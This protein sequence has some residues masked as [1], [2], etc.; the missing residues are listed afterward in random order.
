MAMPRPPRT[1][2]FPKRSRRGINA[3][4]V[5]LAVGATTLLTVPAARGAANY[6]P[7]PSSSGSHLA[8][9]LDPGTTAKIPEAHMKSTMAGITAMAGA[10]LEG[11]GPCP[12]GQIT[13]SLTPGSEKLAK[14]VRSAYGRAV[15][16]SIGLTVWNGQ[17]GRSPHCG[18]LPPW[19]QAPRGLTFSL[20]LRSHRVHAGGSLT[21]RLIARDHRS[22]PFE[23]DTGSVVEGVVVRPGTHD[24]V[25]VYSG[26]IA[27]TGFTLRAASGGSTPSGTAPTVIIGT[28]RCDGET[29]SA[30]SPGK[31]QA[32]VLVMDETGKT[33]R[34]LTP[35]VDLVVT[36]SEDG[37]VPGSHI[38]N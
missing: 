19:S 17:A 26:A 2:P 25:G 5:L 33:P 1:G 31:Y 7:I 10:H 15:L 8:S 14:K 29:G 30:L 27:G 28:A 11:I 36:S 9:C 35:A 18:S 13:L 16:I 6:P 32:V 24:V 21:G 38:R 20:Q 22:A 23:M 34:Y 3:V 37:N 4:V 12:S